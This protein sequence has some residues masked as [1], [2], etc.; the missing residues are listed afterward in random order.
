[1][2]KSYRVFH[3]LLLTSVVSIFGGSFACVYA[4]NE[5][6]EKVTGRVIVKFKEEVPVWYAQQTLKRLNATVAFEIPR[7]RAKVVLFPSAS[8]RVRAMR[9][10]SR[11]PGVAYVELERS[12]A[13]SSIVTPNDP[14]YRPSSLDG[15]HLWRIGAPAAWAI[16]MGRPEVIVAVIDTGVN[17]TDPDLQGKQVPGWNFYNNNADTSDVYGHGTSMASIIAGTTN[18]GIGIA[19]LAGRCRIMPIRISDPQGNGGAGYA[20]WALV[21]AADRGARVALLSWPFFQSA[22]VSQAAQYFMSRGGV[23][24]MPAGNGGGITQLI[25]DSPYLIGVTA[26]TQNNQ[27]AGFAFSG[28]FVDLSAPGVD[29]TQ[30]NRTGYGRG[31]GTCQAAAVAAGVAA[32]VYSANPNLTPTQVET[33]LKSTATDVGPPGRDLETGFGVVNAYR[34]VVRARNLAPD[35]ILPTVSFT[36][37]TNGAVV[38]GDVTVRISATDNVGVASV[39]L[40]LNNTHEIGLAEARTPTFRWNTA[41]VANGAYTLTAI[42]R[43]WEGNERAVSISVTVNNVVD[44]TPPTIRILAPTN[45]TVVSG[46]VAVQVEARDNQRVTRVDFL[47]N[48]RLVSS[49]LVAPFR[50][51]WS[52]TSLPSGT[53]TLQCRAYDPAGNVGWSNTVTVRK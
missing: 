50:I 3:A 24:I 14:L 43:D 2:T 45:N 6:T 30:I 33:I 36:A 18:N 16:T 31:M 11:L 47:V 39:R 26:V 51:T 37:P 41:R 42:A 17:F 23:V 44:T 12:Y 25:P 21:W 28:T 49:T 10:L 29:I 4:T 27:R 20:A 34:A 52:T 40:L 15:W 1:M 7:L 53:Y 19:S 5:P 48:G 9:T 13:P 46:N 22:A 8:H 32:L 38:S 35:R